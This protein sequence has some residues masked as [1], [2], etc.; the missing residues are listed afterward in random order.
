VSINQFKKG[1]TGVVVPTNGAGNTPNL[2]N[3][4]ITPTG[5]IKQRMEDEK[6][7]E[8]A[9]MRQGL[10]LN[11]AKSA[12]EAAKEK[13][14]KYDAL[15]EHYLG[16]YKSEIFNN[17]VAYKDFYD[18]EFDGIDGSS[19]GKQIPKFSA[20]TFLVLADEL[21]EGAATFLR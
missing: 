2:F 17:Q 4:Q 19:E 15:I 18:K 10:E 3:G 12:F 16:Y 9:A 14:S 8:L 13:F 20:Q 11:F 21:S 5:P 1:P 7:P 6:N